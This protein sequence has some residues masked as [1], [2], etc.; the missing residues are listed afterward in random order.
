MG[1]NC[2]EQI[3]NETLNGGNGATKVSTELSP[4]ERIA[5]E[6]VE[7]GC[8][9][10]F[11]VEETVVQP[12]RESFKDRVMRVVRFYAFDRPLSG[13]NTVI[14]SDTTGSVEMRNKEGK[15]VAVAQFFTLRAESIVLFPT[16]L[17]KYNKYPL[18]KSR[19]SKPST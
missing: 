16:L 11:S 15:V 9:H 18:A 7:K 17:E 3:G 4:R 13:D 14:P 5:L 1:T 12:F 10:G 19:Q 8:I 6:Y 2:E